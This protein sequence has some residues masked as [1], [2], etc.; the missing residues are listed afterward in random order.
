MKGILIA[1][2]AL[3]ALIVIVVAIGA[4]LPVKH[5]A[6]RAAQYRQSPDAIWK[7]IVNYRDYPQWRKT[8]TRI[9]PLGEFGGNPAWREID[10]HGG[11]IPFVIVESSEPGRVVTRI[12]DPT[13]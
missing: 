6:S 12:S 5:T 8:V 1:V 11:G 2:V 3:V 9:E 10:S 4:M 7:A 13:S